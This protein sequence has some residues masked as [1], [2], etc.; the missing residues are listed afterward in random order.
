MLQCCDFKVSEKKDKNDTQTYFTEVSN[1]N[2]DITRQKSELPFLKQSSDLS[3]L[4]K[5]AKCSLENS[6]SMGKEGALKTR[7][8]IQ[9]S[10]SHLCMEFAGNCCF[11]MGKPL[12]NAGDIVQGCSY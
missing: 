10:S 8:P 11:K 5:N 4:P 2:K 7:F 9:L 1:D 6:F 12:H 3:T